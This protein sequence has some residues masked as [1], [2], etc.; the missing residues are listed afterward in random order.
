[1]DITNKELLEI[2]TKI[3][4]EGK[5]FYSELAKHVEDPEV[6]GFLHTMAKE[7]ALHEKQFHQ[8]LKDKGSDDYGWEN[9]ESLRTLAAD[10]Y[11][12]DIFPSIDEIFEQLPNF[13]GI[14]KALDFALE[15]EKVSSEF[16]GLMQESCENIEGKTLLILLE[17]AEQEHLEQVEILRDRYLN[18]SE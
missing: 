4:Q 13:Q 5:V 14:R 6:K 12:T 15:A 8:L 3:E 9:N 7:E 18:K 17:I 1:M 10:I 2:S 11:K 16:Y